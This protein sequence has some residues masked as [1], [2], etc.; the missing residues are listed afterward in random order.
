M[1]GQR[2]SRLKVI[3]AVHGYDA[4]DRD[5]IPAL[6]TRTGFGSTAD[7][8]GRRL[9]SAYAARAEEKG[10]NRVCCKLLV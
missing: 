9:L 2:G 4:K 1:I 6:T 8:R 5:R 10:F 7:A 3:S